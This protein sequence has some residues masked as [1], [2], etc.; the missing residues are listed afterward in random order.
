[1]EKKMKPSKHIGEVF[2]TIYHPDG[3]IEK[4]KMEFNLVVDS[5]SKLIASLIKFENGYNTGKL[6]W[7]F[8][9][10]QASWDTT[11]YSPLPGTTKLVNEV[12]RKEILPSQRSFIDEAGAKTSVVTDR[13]QLDIIIENSEMDG[14]SLR[15]F[16]IFGGNATTVKNSGIQINHKTH[17]RI[18]KVAGMRIERSVRF[19]F[20]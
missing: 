2:D 17:S 18:D 15:E 5:I 20:N 12:Y 10:G 16:G 13:L 11:P 14:I 1:M 8:G 9:I 7:A 19:T 4:R 3:R 6:F